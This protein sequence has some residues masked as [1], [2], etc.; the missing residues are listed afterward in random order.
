MDIA[1]FLIGYQAGQNKASNGDSYNLS[2]AEMMMKRDAEPFSGD[3][4]RLSLRRFV[5]SNGAT[6]GGLN[7]YSFAGFSDV[8]YMAFSDI[9]QVS[10]YALRDN[11]NLKLLDIVVPSVSGF[12]GVYFNANSLDGCTALESIIVRPSK[13][14]L[15]SVAF[16]EGA[17][18]GTTSDFYVYIPSEYYDALVSGLDSTTLAEVPASRFRKLEDYPSIDNWDSTT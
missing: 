14:G 13:I 5:L 18:N 2:L 3:K 17:T 1:S 12:D 9:V 16:R 8:Q 10:A 11:K 6:L 4:T 7:K 15:S